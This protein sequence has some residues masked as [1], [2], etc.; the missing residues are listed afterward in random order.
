LDRKTRKLLTILGQHQPKADGDCLYVP[1]KWRRRGL[2]KLEE[3]Y[4][5]EVMKVKEY[6]DSQEHKLS[7][8]TK[9]ITGR[10]KTNK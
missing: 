2:M 5:V 7:S 6:V 1:R 10:N 9:R 8:V 3:V 4:I